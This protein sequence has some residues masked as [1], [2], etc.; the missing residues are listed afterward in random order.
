[1]TEKTIGTLQWFNE[2]E[3]YGHIKLDWKPDLMVVTRSVEHLGIK[4]LSP[5][6]R[7]RFTIEQGPNG[8]QAENVERV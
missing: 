8:P 5:G 6:Q 4:T 2:H 7:L 1:M 3:G